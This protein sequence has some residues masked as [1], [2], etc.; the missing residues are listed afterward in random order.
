MDALMDS[1][2]V[3]AMVEHRDNDIEMRIHFKKHIFET[4]EDDVVRVSFPV[5]LHNAN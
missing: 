2:V 4:L 3:I 1:Q 5:V